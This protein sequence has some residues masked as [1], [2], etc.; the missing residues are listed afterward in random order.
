MRRGMRGRTKVSREHRHMSLGVRS[1]VW[2]WGGV[3]GSARYS[4][5]RKEDECGA[6]YQGFWVRGGW[7]LRWSQDLG[8]TQALEAAVWE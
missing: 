5:G 4:G 7:S 6:G 2:R 1:G 8:G 3:W